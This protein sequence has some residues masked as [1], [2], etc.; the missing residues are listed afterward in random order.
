[1]NNLV[2]SD[3][4]MSTVR[5]FFSLCLL[6]D[7]GPIPVRLWAC[8]QYVASC[9]LPPLAACQ[10]QQR[11][12]HLKSVSDMCGGA[13]SP[14]QASPI[15]GVAPVLPVSHRGH[16]PNLTFLPGLLL[17]PTDSCIS[18]LGCFIKATQ[19]SLPFS[20]HISNSLRKYSV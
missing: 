5:P 18:T 2:R 19:M 14:D 12:L 8:E 4:V 1:M 3:C 6:V 7:R 10:E 15:S 16:L 13:C 11:R 17:A 9:I 20:F